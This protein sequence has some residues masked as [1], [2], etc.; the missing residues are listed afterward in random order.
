MWLTS[1]YLK[2]FSHQLLLLLLYESFAKLTPY[3]AIDV[4]FPKSKFM[5]KILSNEFW[6][7]FLDIHMNEKGTTC[8]DSHGFKW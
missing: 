1:F 7:E 6:F 2:F 3:D 4:C 5:F 8:H